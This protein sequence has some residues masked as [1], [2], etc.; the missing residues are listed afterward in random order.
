MIPKIGNTEKI[1]FTFNGGDIFFK[2]DLIEPKKGEK[3]E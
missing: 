2:K 3:E 1:Y